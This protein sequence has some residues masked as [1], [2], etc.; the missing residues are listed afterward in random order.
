MIHSF[1]RLI[2]P[3]P[4]DESDDVAFVSDDD[5]NDDDD[6]TTLLPWLRNLD[7]IWV[8]SLLRS[9]APLPSYCCDALGA[10]E[11]TEWNGDSAMGGLVEA[12]YYERKLCS[13]P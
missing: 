6:D 9:S 7:I 1:E 10:L 13:D 5:D 3:A 8:S 4:L 2:P 11:K 12:Q